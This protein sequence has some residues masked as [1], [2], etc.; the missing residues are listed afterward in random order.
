M[1]RKCTHF[2]GIYITENIFIKFVIGRLRLF[3]IFCDHTL[4]LHNVNLCEIILQAYST[5]CSHAQAAYVTL[6]FY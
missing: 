5:K 4:W 6:Q 1:F 2:D 3:Y